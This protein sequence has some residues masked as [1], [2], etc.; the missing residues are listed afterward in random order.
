MVLVWLSRA[1]DSIILAGNGCYE[2]YLLRWSVIDHTL[3]LICSY[4]ELKWYEWISIPDSID[5]LIVFDSSWMIIQADQCEYMVVREWRS[6]GR[7]MTLLCVNTSLSYCFVSMC[8][9]WWWVDNQ[10]VW[11]YLTINHWFVNNEEC[12]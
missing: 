10:T 5:N 6:V 11:W 12:W 9:D 1:V 2:L 8:M 3:C 4:P 7:S